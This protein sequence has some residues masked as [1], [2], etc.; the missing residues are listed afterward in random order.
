[1][2]LRGKYMADTDIISSVPNLSTLL[3]NMPYVR[4]VG[5]AT[6]TKGARLAVTGTIV[7]SNAGATSRTLINST[8]FKSLTGFDWDFTRVAVYASAGN[9]TN[10]EFYPVGVIQN[11]AGCYCLFNM[12]VPSPIRVNFGLLM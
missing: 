3:N 6:D 8:Q 5:N 9:Q 7:F 2:K 10:P 1:M 12:K 4:S 11:E